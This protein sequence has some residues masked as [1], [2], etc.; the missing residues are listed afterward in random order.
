[1]RLIRSSMDA[2]ADNGSVMTDH[3]YVTNWSDVRFNAAAAATT[4]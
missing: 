4:I 1:M 2:S 3:G